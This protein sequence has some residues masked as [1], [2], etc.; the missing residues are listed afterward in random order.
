[1][2]PE[3]SPQLQLLIVVA[4]AVVLCALAGRFLFVLFRRRQLQRKS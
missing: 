1:V 3:V 2:Q 4:T